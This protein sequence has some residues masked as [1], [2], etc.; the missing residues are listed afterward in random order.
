MNEN[1]SNFRNCILS[2]VLGASIVAGA[3]YIILVE[4]SEQ[5]IGQLTGELSTSIEQ[6]RV[7]RGYLSEASRI[8]VASGDSFQKLRDLFKLLQEAE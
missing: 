4:P 8:L 6:N 3:G 7:S 1:K 2:F 5:R